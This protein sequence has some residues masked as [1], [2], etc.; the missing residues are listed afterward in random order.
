MQCPQCQHENLLDA[1]FCDECGSRL[2]VTCPACGEANRAGAKFCRKCGQALTHLTDA[3]QS[4]SQTL[5]C[6]SD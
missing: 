4:A 6:L 5:G 1:G 3:R 2:E